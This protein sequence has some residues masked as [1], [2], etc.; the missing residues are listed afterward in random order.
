[1][2]VGM[3]HSSYGSNVPSGENVSY[4]SE[5]AVLE[6]QGVHVVPYV[7]EVPDRARNELLPMISAAVTSVFSCAVYFDIKRF[8][9]ENEIDVAHIQNT[10][11]A[12]GSA[13]VRGI[14]DAL[15]KVPIVQ[16]VRNLRMQC[17]TGELFRA[18]RDCRECIDGPSAVSCIRNR[19]YHDS[20]AASVAAVASF[21]ASR[22][23]G[24]FSKEVDVFVCVSEFVRSAMLAS[25]FAP[26]RL[27]VKPNVAYPS[28]RVEGSGDGFLYLGRL[29]AEK[30]VRLLMN[31]WRSVPKDLCL[32]IVG[33]GPL[34]EEVDAFSREFSNVTVL[35][36][37]DHAGAMREIGRARAV[38]APS[39]WNEPFGRI[40]CES[41]AMAVPCIVSARGGLPELVRDGSTG[42]IFDVQEV[43]GLARAIQKVAQ[44]SEVV[45]SAMRSAALS[46]FEMR[47]SP[48]ANS[49]ALSEIY[50]K[51]LASRR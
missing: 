26:E 2:K 3:F 33:D 49:R 25:G 13:V 11:P 35:G 31:A 9:V 21:H 46:E 6:G 48:S 47:F 16:A 7:R 15:P 43:D 51:A 38:I 5:K 29:S 23:I 4:I 10:F 1:M 8:V 36:K 41:F 42:Y 34:R 30:G 27:V 44:C 40:V 14:R 18:G 37:M 19:C 39:L 28:T 32:K 50:A 22:L 20:T 45:Y 24:S 17:P 12:L